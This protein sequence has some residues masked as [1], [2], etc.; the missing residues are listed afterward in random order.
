MNNTSSEK[1]TKEPEQK[2]IQTQKQ[3][4][5]NQSLSQKKQKQIQTQKKQIQT[6]KKQI[7]TQ[8]KQ[9]HTQKKQNQTQ[10]KQI[11]TEKQINSP[12]QNNRITETKQ[13]VVIISKPEPEEENNPMKYSDKLKHL[14]FKI[15]SQNNFSDGGI[16]F[17][18]K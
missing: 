12:K 1:K 7:Q 13:N 16:R 10:K 4:L 6:Q 15:K 3:I 14:L 18:W 9:N 2:Q 17:A 11:P 5:P 8:K